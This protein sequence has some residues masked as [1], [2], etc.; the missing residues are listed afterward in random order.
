[1]KLTVMVLFA[2]FS[3]LSAQESNA[4]SVLRGPYLGQKEPGLK[5]EL[6]APGSVST[7]LNELNAAFSPDGSEFYFSIRN[8]WQMVV[9]VMKKDGERWRQPEAAPFSSMEYSTSDPFFSSDGNTLFFCSNRPS[10][11]RKNSSDWNIWAMRRTG[12]KWGDP[13]Y[14]SFNTEKNELYVSAARNGNIY[15]GADYGNKTGAFDINKTDLYVSRFDGKN[16]LPAEKL[17]DSVNEADYPEWDPF[18]A[19]D[20]S[21]I[22]FTSTKPGG[23][24][25]GDMYISFRKPDGSWSGARNMGS[26]TNSSSQDYCPNLSPDGKY[27]FFT[28]YRAKPFSKNLSYGEL[29]EY[30]NG[31]QNGSGGDIYWISSRI[32]EQLKEEYLTRK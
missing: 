7:G 23:F 13:E 6:F 18:I 3:T 10:P 24:G 19:P 25:S 2:L 20:E 21:Y 26:K 27:L 31:P 22:I 4:A 9:C 28:S 15:F 30:L 12:G 5:A 14:L 17:S 32:I 11:L 16:Y 8:G 29:R 1:M